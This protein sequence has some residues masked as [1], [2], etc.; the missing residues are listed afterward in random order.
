M[1]KLPNTLD[2]NAELIVVLSISELPLAIRN[3]LMAAMNLRF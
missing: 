1:K 3:E 2:Q